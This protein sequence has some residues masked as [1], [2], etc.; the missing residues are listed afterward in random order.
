MEDFKI[1]LWQ[2]T[3]KRADGTQFSSF[4]NNGVFNG[5]DCWW[6]GYRKSVTKKDGT[7]VEVVEIVIKP[8]ADITK[9]RD[10]MDMGKTTMAIDGIPTDT[11]PISEIPF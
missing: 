9:P 1:T 7:Q 6:N 5:V 3:A 10:P 8:K 2:K 4:S 11:T